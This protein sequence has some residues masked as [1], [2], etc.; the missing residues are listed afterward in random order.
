MMDLKLRETVSSFPPFLMRRTPEDS[1]WPAW[2][3]GARRALTISAADKVIILGI[4]IGKKSA[5]KTEAHH[6][7]PLFSYT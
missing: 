2:V 3:F 1:S 6:D 5:N 7:S 4:R